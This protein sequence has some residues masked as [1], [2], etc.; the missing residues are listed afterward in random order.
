MAKADSISGIQFMFDPCPAEGFVFS[1][2]IPGGS[3]LFWFF[4][5]CF[6]KQ[7]IFLVFLS[8]VT[9]PA[10]DVGEFPSN[11]LGFY[12]S[13]TDTDRVLAYAQQEYADGVIPATASGLNV[14]RAQWKNSDP[15]ESR[16]GY[17]TVSLNNFVLAN[18]TINT[19]DIHLRYDASRNLALTFRRLHSKGWRH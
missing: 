16:A 1:A 8:K 17:I 14:W 10:Q 9:F 11:G 5:S 3:F 18:T 12:F 6:W 15:S 19:K 2:K 7:R 13:T 4:Q